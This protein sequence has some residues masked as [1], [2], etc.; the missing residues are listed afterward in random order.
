MDWKRLTYLD[1]F[2]GVPLAGG[3]LVYGIYCIVMQQGVLVF[4]SH[5]IEHGSISDGLNVYGTAAV[6]TGISY[7]VWA[8]FCHF[9]GIWKA[10]RKLDRETWGKIGMGL[11]AAGVV[12]V[13]WAMFSM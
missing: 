3:L 10:Y 12:C 1:W 9:A 5:R 13:L 11:F 2:L 8:A 7:L 6:R 4:P